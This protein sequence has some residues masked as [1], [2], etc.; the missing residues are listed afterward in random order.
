MKYIILIVIICALYRFAV[1][2]YINPY[3]LYLVFGKKGSGKS[4]YLV[5]LAMRYQKKKYIVYTN[6]ADIMLPDV[7]I[8]NTDDLGDFVPVSNSVLLI[9]EAGI[10]YDNRKYKQFKDST[11]DFY[12]YQRHYKVVCYLAT[13]N[14]DIDK[15]LRDLVD[16]MFLCQNIAT[17]F[18]L[19]RP[20]RKKITLTEA[21]SEGE[22]RITENLK[23]QSIFSWKVF[24]IPKY[25]KFFESFIAPEKPELQ[26]KIPET[27][28]TKKKKKK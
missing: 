27:I 16:G 4:S 19:L 6:M 12:K 11:R 28:Y 22:S 24:Y 18:C 9:D 21:T 13:Q 20:I 23:F 25:G 3:K 2:K 7:R 5:K 17:V 8:I 10:V 15:K 1:R 26:F 14:Y